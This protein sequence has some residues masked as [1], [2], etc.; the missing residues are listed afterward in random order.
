MDIFTG[1]YGFFDYKYNIAGYS[2]QDYGGFAQYLYLMIS[3]ALLTALLVVLRKTPRERVRKIV[4]WLGV[5]LV[6][7]YVG[8]TTWESYYDIRQ[9]GGFN[10]G[11]LPFDTCS[12][13]MPAAILAGFGKGRV[14][15][16]AECWIATG[17][18]VGG[19]ATMLFLN[20]FKWYPFLSFGATYSMVWHF[21]MVF[22]GLLILV[23]SRPPLRFSLVTD[24]YL[25][26]L[27]ASVVVIPIDFIFGFDFMLYRDL[28][29]VPFFEGLAS[30]MK[31]AGVGFLNP[32]LMLVLYFA[33]FCIIFVLAAGIK[34]RKKNAARSPAA[35]NE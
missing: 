1:D 9:A 6:V 34:N 14:Q 15:R 8:K 19:F 27:V 28:G 4:G 25:F 32:V 26:H 29:G 23:T 18:I 20:A 5:F 2:G 24:G 12:L 30:R 7:F 3:A 16:M 31:T 35:T 21:L 33:A 11:L 13:I 10:T 22:M 17:G